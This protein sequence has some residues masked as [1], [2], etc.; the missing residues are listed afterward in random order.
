MSQRQPKPT[1]PAEELWIEKLEALKREAL[2]DESLAGIAVILG[3]TIDAVENGIEDQAAAV[4]RG[5]VDERVKR[6][7]EV[8]NG[9]GR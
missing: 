3:A 7:R 5:F 4:I 1:V 2:Q 8:R 6:L 9:R